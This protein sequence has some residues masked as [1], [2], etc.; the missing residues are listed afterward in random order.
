MITPN[1][2]MLKINDNLKWDWQACYQETMQVFNYS[3]EENNDYKNSCNKLRE[4]LNQIQQHVITLAQ[5]LP[6]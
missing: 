6:Q 3:G 2:E 1:V 4:R 5:N